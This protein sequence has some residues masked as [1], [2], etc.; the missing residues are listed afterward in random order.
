MVISR[1]QYINQPAGDKMIA[2]LLMAILNWLRQTVGM[3]Y[4]E[5]LLLLLAGFAVGV[6][7]ARRK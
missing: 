4:G 5:M 6:W 2:E 1:F 3:Q 7:V